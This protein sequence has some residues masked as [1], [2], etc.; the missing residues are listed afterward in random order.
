MA[1]Q[2][3]FDDGDLKKLDERLQKAGD[4]FPKLAEEFTSEMAGE[5]LAILQRQIAS[6]LNDSRGDV[7]SW[8]EKQIGSR[9]RYAAVRAKGGK[10]VKKGYYTKKKGYRTA[11][12]P[13]RTAYITNAL[14][15]GFKTRQPSGRAKYTPRRHYNKVPGRKFYNAAW[16]EIEPLA[17]E[18]AVE[19]AKTLADKIGGD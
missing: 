10:S 18:R 6:K 12:K 19:L 2:L 9:K 5:G 16:A 17:N 15:S 8:Q 1:N 7:Q 3:L 11:K 4:A 14:D 13:Y